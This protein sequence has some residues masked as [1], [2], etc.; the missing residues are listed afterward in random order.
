MTMLANPERLGW[1]AIAAAL[2]PPPPV[3]Y[4]AWAVEHIS[5]SKRESQEAGPYNADRFSYFNEV[6]RALSPDDPC[7]TVTLAK[8][9]QLGGTVIAL[10][11]ACGSLDMDPGDLMYSHPTESNAERWSKMKLAPMLRGSPALSALFPQKARNG[12]D[13]VTYKE[14]ADG[15]GAILISGANSPATL[16]QVTMPRQVQDDLSKWERNN[17]GDPEIQADSRSFGVE[18]A[19]ILKVSTPLVDPGC[20]ITRNYE[21]GSQERPFVP[22]PHCGHMQVLEWE[23]MLAGLDEDHPEEAHF[24]CIDCGAVIEEHH[25][26][27]MLASL[28]WRADNPRAMREH[29]SF[30]IWSAYSHLQSWRRIAQAWIRAKGDPAS[31][32]VF[33]N[34]TVGKVFKTQGESPPWEG[35]RNR[36]DASRYARGTIPKGALLITIGMDVQIDRVEWQAVGFGREYRRFVIDHGVAPGHISEPKTQAIL[37]ALLDQEWPNEVGN[38]IKADLTAIDGNAWT[39]DVWG[40]AQKHP[41]SR[42]IMVRGRGEEWAPMLARVTK[43]RDARGN[44]LKY[45]ARF[46]N[47][48]ASIL[49]MALYRNLAKTDVDGRGYVSF[50]RGL[51]DEYFRQLTAERRAPSSRL[52]HTIYRWVKDPRQ[53]NECLDTMNQAEAAALK[54][55]LR[56]MPD[57]IWSKLEVDRETAR[58]AMSGPRVPEITTA[59]R[60]TRKAVSSRYM[61]D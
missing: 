61:R 29:R 44:L 15:L 38:R 16:S 50:P 21:A 18:F 52:G 41:T 47:F 13:S 58:T 17:A 2:S 54:L 37:T 45:S 8:S 46:Y 7:R 10:I 9:A 36:A 42:V 59:P 28:E 33:L 32:Q 57:R 51:D 22:C 56:G 27:G 24:T 26:P 25:R 48:G 19:K 4:L 5:F 39:E 14:R 34:D 11:F 53:A 55:G 20:R 60:R 6:F 43:E 12:S 23:N 3:D 35:L 30:Y 31:E 1:E 40:W 49:K